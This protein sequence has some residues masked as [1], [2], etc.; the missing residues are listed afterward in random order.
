MP[1]E[2]KIDQ[3]IIKGTS[4]GEEVKKKIIQVTALNSGS[5]V[6]WEASQIYYPKVIPCSFESKENSS[7][8]RVKCSPTHKSFTFCH[9]G[10]FLCIVGISPTD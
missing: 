9:L 2:K 3:F 8:W 5:G 1:Y 4:K 6:C 10:H 7:G